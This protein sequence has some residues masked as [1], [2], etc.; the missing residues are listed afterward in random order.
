M[1]GYCNLRIILPLL[2]VSAWLAMVPAVL[3]AQADIG[4]LQRAAESGDAKAQFELGERLLWGLGVPASPQEAGEL[5]ATSAGSGN[6]DAMRVLG[7]NL[8]GGWVLEQDKALGRDLLDRAIAAGDAGAMVAL[9]RFHLYGDPL[10]SDETR[11]LAL[12]EDA[13]TRGN[14]EGLHAYGEQLMWGKKDP[15]RAE[16]YLT[17]SAELGVGAAWSTLAEGAMYGYLGEKKRR[18]FVGFADK[19]AAEGETRIAVLEAQRRLYGINMRASGP[20]AIAG[21]EKAADAGNPDAA[22]FLISLV[23]DG[24]RLNVR[25]TPDRAEAYL[26][27]YADLI[28]EKES[29]RLAYTIRVARSRQL[30]DFPAFAEAYDS[31]PDLQSV[32]FA[33]ELLSANANFA[34]YLLQR[35]LREMGLYKGALDGYAGTGTLRAL[36]DACLGLPNTT[37]CGDTIMHPSVISRLITR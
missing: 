29:A 19:A 10:P 12:F 27:K 9:G 1:F 32:A 35:R 18:R 37:R 5:L 31:R 34:I 16:D 6:V 8:I 23:R 20:K 13:A 14:G 30:P 24:N 4:A 17:R 25:K 3:A 33:R 15:R 11:A 36:W 22:R 26:E 7:E 28:G 21:L 2:A